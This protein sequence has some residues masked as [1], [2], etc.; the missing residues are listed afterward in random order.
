M[1]SYTFTSTA[2]AVL[3]R[4]A[5][6]VFADVN[7]DDANLDFKS[8][9]KKINKKTKAIIVVHYCG[10]SCNMDKFLEIKRENNIRLMEDCAGWFGGKF[11]KKYLVTIGYFDA[12][13]FH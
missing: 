11:K 9:K 12:F 13:S 8:V 4:G 7:L 5:K 1:P 2:N 3:L 6:P 10:N